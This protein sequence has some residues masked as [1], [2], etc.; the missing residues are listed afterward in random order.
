MNLQ[1]EIIRSARKSIGITVECD[2]RVVVRAPHQASDQSVSAA[3]ASKRFCIWEKL[4]DPNKYPDP[5]PA[6]E[7]VTGETFLY[8][9]QPYALV[10][11]DG[12]VGTLELVGERFEAANV[13]RD[14]CN[15]LFK[16][17]YLGR[18][19]ACLGPRIATLAAEMGITYRRICVRELR[20]RWGSC[21]PGGTLSFNRRI[22]QAPMI[23][24]DYLIVH[25][26]ARVREPNHSPDFW[27]LVAV[28]APTWVS[29]RDWL[30]RNGSWLEW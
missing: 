5:L 1:Y 3:V 15:E 10:L 8:L 19:R 27:N 23:V 9:G 21:T 24:V 4:R 14:R 7:Y 17:W 16:A 29:A 18:A 26:L 12:S 28:H 22:V 13:D 30:K 11:T 2:R 20:Y 6:K 25:E